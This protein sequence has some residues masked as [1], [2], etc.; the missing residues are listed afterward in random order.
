K[1]MRK[2][3]VTMKTEKKDYSGLMALG[4]TVLER[5]TGNIHIPESS[6]LPLFAAE[7]DKLKACIATW[8]P[9]GSRGSHLDYVNLLVQAEKVW[10][11]LKGLLNYVTTS[12]IVIA[13]NNYPQ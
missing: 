9:Q 10:L 12:A 4:T 5:L 3:T 2:P 1:E 8:G 7:L 6:S 11:I 13:G